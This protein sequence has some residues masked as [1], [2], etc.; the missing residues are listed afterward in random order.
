MTNIKY[1]ANNHSAVEVPADYRRGVI[2]NQL[3]VFDSRWI[4]LPTGI[5][6]EIVGMAGDLLESQ[7]DEIYP[8]L[9]MDNLSE[10]F[11][12]KLETTLIIKASKIKDGQ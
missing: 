7:W 9:R 10:T 3:L 6:W 8:L 12:F 11:G 1:I 4:T 2:C 5:E